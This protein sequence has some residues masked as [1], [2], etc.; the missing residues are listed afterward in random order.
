MEACDV[1]SHVLVILRSYAC[2]WRHRVRAIDGNLTVIAGIRQRRDRQCHVKI[3]NLRPFAEYSVRPNRRPTFGDAP[4]ST[5]QSS[6]RLSTFEQPWPWNRRAS[7]LEVA[8]VRLDR[9]T[10]TVQASRRCSARRAQRGPVIDRNEMPSCA[11]DSHW[12]TCCAR[13]AAKDPHRQSG[14][15]S[16]ADGA[17][18]CTSCSLRPFF[19]SRPWP[20]TVSDQRQ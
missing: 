14:C 9:R 11:R 2:A 15:T 18:A 13:E 16:A 6:R 3:I 20:K 19:C 1:T 7:R 8:G 4:G 5:Y 10:V 12:D 17:S